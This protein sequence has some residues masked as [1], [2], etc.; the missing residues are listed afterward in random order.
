MDITIILAALTMIFPF[1]GFLVIGLFAKKAKGW[2]PRLGTIMMGLALASAIAVLVIVSINTYNGVKPAV[3]SF[4][5]MKFDGVVNGV[6]KTFV[7]DFG[8]RIDFISAVMLVVV[9]LVSFLVHLFSIDYM[10][11]DPGIARFYAELQLFTMSMLGVVTASNLLQLFM[12]WELVGLCSYLLIGFWF[13]KRSAYQAA[14]KAFFVTKVGDAGLFIGI[15]IVFMATG[16]LSLIDLPAIWA[17]AGLVTPLVGI[18]IFMGA[19]GKSAQFPLHVWLPNAMEGPTPV[20]ALIHAATMVAAGVYMVSRTLFLFTQDAL[21]VVMCIGGFTAFFAAT[22]ATVQE[23]IKKVLAYSTISQL[24]YMVLGLGSV[25]VGG[26]EG[27]HAGEAAAATTVLV[28]G[29]CIAAFFHLMTH[30]FFKGLLF[31]GSGSVIHATHTQNMHEM[32]G[33]YKKMK[34]TGLTFI[35]GSIALAGIF[36]FAGFWSKDMILAN[37]FSVASDPKIPWV[38]WVPFIMAM[39][40]AFMTPYYMTR[41]VWLTFFGKP[42]KENHAHEAS[43]RT[44]APLIILAVF[45][46]VIGLV[47]SPFLGEIFQKLIHPEFHEEINWLVLW[48]STGLALLGIFVSA[49]IYIWQWVKRETLIKAFRPIYI[50]LKNKWYI[51]EA[52]TF[53][54]IK[55]MFFFAK[56][57]LWTDQHVV[58]GMVN[59]AAWLARQ[60]GKICYWFDQHIVDGMVNG[61]GWLG[62]TL[63]NFARIFDKYVI[64]GFIDGM[65]AFFGWLSGKTRKAQTGYVQNYAAVMF[66]SLAVILI[67]IIIVFIRR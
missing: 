27:G 21:L 11:G 52:W 49:S 12:F 60:W 44:T 64:D 41:C 67:V 3:E 43:W 20:S 14:K 10:H 31:L 9:T 38:A 4:T 56:V 23:D 55:P 24:G 63:G 53:I 48:G 58:D 16:T 39:C 35:L 59:G 18:L 51:D 33:L 47:G 50:F 17:A 19:V 13:A 5:W 34:T 8:F 65:A 15:V 26:I 7:L 25:V 62:V 30:A 2:A 6:A 37:A 29:G 42:R 54:A 22:I 66:A 28:S 40:A 45:A 1:L 32:G 46:V 36:P 57:F 61:A